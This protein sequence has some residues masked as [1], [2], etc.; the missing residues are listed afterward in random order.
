M[1]KVGGE[2]QKEREVDACLAFSG[3]E[4]TKCSPL[5][6]QGKQPADVSQ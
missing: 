5:S 4:K 2:V 1:G 3:N 6:S